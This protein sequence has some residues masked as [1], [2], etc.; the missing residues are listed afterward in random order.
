MHWWQQRTTSICTLYTGT[1]LAV[2][3]YGHTVAIWQ[4]CPN[5]WLHQA[6]GIGSI[7]LAYW[8]DW[9]ELLYHLY[10]SNS[11]LIDES[12]QYRHR[13]CV[14]GQFTWFK[15]LV[16]VPSTELLFTWLCFLYTIFSQ[17]KLSPLQT[18]LV[19]QLNKICSSSSPT[20]RRVLLLSYYKV[21]IANFWVL[22]S[23]QL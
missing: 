22:I 1:S 10:G 19:F 3:S 14:L 11:L 2:L 9:I 18:L 12:S 23:S 8:P 17:A 7:S 13:S 6:M 5:N 16:S 21:Q 20:A 15:K 4:Q